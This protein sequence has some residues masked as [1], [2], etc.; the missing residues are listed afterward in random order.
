MNLIF[1]FILLLAVFGGRFVRYSVFGI[2]VTYIV[3]FLLCCRYIV[4]IELT[5]S[6][7]CGLFFNKA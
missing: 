4:Y 3:V 5:H 1:I 2:S 6:Y 7:E